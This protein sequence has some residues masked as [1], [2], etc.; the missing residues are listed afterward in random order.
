MALQRPPQLVMGA[1][2]TAR[3]VPRGTAGPSLKQEHSFGGR[4]LT[5]QPG[6]TVTQRRPFITLEWDRC[7][8]KTASRAWGTAWGPTSVSNPVR[9]PRLLFRG[10]LSRVTFVL[11]LAAALGAIGLGLIAAWAWDQRQR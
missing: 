3:T 4:L 10:R 6:L 1:R 5:A 2:A 9:S 7:S 8:C 11:V